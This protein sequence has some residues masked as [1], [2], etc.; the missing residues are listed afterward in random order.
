MQY[1]HLNV[2]ISLLKLTFIRFHICSGLISSTCSAGDSS[3]GLRLE[4]QLMSYTQ[5]LNQVVAS[6]V[7]STE[8]DLVCLISQSGLCHRFQLCIL[9]F[10]QKF[11]F[12]FLNATYTPTL[13]FEDV[14]LYRHDRICCASL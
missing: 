10:G 14:W 1:S 11:R 9:H 2:F 3:S 5:Q 8:R 6:F 12:L 13:S 4:Q 7:I